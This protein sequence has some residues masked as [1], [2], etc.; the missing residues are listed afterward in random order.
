MADLASD[1]RLAVDSGRAAL[2]INEVVHSIK[3]SDA[4]LVVAAEK[5]K[6]ENL[7]DVMHM[8]KIA[9][10]KVLIYPGNSMELGA[11]CGKPY[12]VSVL[13]VSEQGNS[14]ILEEDYSAYEGTNK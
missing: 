14:K 5:N 2:G 4:K 9:G 12:S 3:G 7:R 6:A 8:A 1:I 10:I 11:V 13:S